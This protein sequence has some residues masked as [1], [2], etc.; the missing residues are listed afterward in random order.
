MEKVKEFKNNPRKISEFEKKRLEENINKLGDL[1][2]IV[3]DIGTNEIITGNQRSKVID[4]DNCTVELTHER[5][6]YDYMYQYGVPITQ[7]RVSSVQHE[8]S[9]RSLFYMQE[10]ESDTWNKLVKRLNGV[11]TVGQLGKDQFFAPKE[12]PDMFDNWIEYRDYLLDNLIEK[13]NKPKYRDKFQKLDKKYYKIGEVS[14]LYRVMVQTIIVNDSAF[15]KLQNYENNAYVIAFR[16]YLKK[17]EM[18]RHGDNK[19]I[20]YYKAKYETN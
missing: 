20:N 8:T 6:I 13:K 11:N 1:S 14:G 10:V 17:G 9:I 18:N 4:F 12:L 16:N 15:T 19:F 2:G 3:H 5:K 7:M